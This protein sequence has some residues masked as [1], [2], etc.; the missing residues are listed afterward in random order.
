MSPR[1]RPDREMALER[2]ARSPDGAG[3]HA[4]LWQ[5]VARLFV[6]LRPASGGGG[7]EDARPL[8][9]LAL[10]GL[11]RGLPHEA[12]GRPRPGDRLREGGRLLSVEGVTEADRA[13]R[14]LLLYLSEEVAR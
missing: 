12:P 8:S 13:G 14:F 6:D 1:P 3:G 9:R 5:E 11:I 7:V 10:R 2:A 4:R